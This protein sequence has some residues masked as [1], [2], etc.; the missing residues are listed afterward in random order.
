MTTQNCIALHLPASLGLPQTGLYWLSVPADGVPADLLQDVAPYLDAR[1]DDYRGRSLTVTAPTWDAVRVAVEAERAKRSEEARVTAERKATAGEKWRSCAA[2]YLAGESVSLSLYSD[3]AWVDG[4]SSAHGDVTAEEVAAVNAEHARR[5]AGAQAK[6]EAERQERAA[7]LLAVLPRILAGEGTIHSFD[8]TVTIDGTK[9]GTDDSGPDV[10]AQIASEKQRR[11]D[12]IA[13]AEAD[14][15]TA[16][17]GTIDQSTFERR[18]GGYCTD[19]QWRETLTRAASAQL[20]RELET[21]GVTC[22]GPSYVGGTTTRALTDVQYAALAPVLAYAREHGIA[23]E[24]ISAFD[25]ATETTCENH[26]EHDDDCSDCTTEYSGRRAI[27]KL[28]RRVGS[29]SGEG[30]VVATARVELGAY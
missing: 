23:V 11:T 12:A 8:R 25:S 21:L 27:A 15:I 2:R 28:S 19:G 9:H 22:G 6:R 14:A 10:V 20:K 1:R 7:A 17:V 5:E 26:E 3:S 16:L 24:T 13:A 29:V 4:I 18:E 30:D